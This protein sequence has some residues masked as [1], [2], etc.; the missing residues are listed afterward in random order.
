MSEN[1]LILG[2]GIGKE[3]SNESEA[4]WPSGS[5]TGSIPTPYN[6]EPSGTE[7]DSSAKNFSDDS[8]SNRLSHS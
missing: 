2:S 6:F 7:S 4:K 3:E 1:E 8:D 5:E